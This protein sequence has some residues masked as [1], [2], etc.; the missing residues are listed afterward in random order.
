[1]SEISE[2]DPIKISEDVPRLSEAVSKVP[3]R[4]RCV[5]PKKRRY[6]AF[7]LKFVSWGNK[8]G[9]DSPIVENLTARF[10]KVKLSP[11]LKN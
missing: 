6:K 1:M 11:H 8:L 3:T 9:S 10:S 7:D 4:P 2:E 5:L